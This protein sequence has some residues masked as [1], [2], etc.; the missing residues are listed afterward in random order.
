[1]CSP[2]EVAAERLR[3]VDLGAHWEFNL[4]THSSHSPRF[5]PFGI[6]GAW[7]ALNGP[8]LQGFA[9]LS[10]KTSLG[11]PEQDRVGRVPCFQGQATKTADTV[12]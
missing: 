3:G 1:M 8:W 12:R 2:I 10:K 11:W 6:G 9:P 4:K 5:M 7:E